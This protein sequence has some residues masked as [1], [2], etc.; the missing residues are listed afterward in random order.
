MVHRRLVYIYLLNV[1]S[2]SSR[3]FSKI[4]LTPRLGRLLA[5]SLEILPHG[6]LKA[7][8]LGL[9]LSPSAHAGSRIHGSM[10]LVYH[11]NRHD[12]YAFILET[13][14]QFSGVPRCEQ[15]GPAALFKLPL[16]E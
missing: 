10:V 11:G 2:F 5:L 16:P 3:Y 8:G 12:A 13:L 4:K 7:C 1:P 6:A 9:A 14:M 15:L